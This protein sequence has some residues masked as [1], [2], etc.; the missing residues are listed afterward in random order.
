MHFKSFFFSTFFSGHWPDCP[1]GNPRFFPTKAAKSLHNSPSRCLYPSLIL[2][3]YKSFKKS[4]MAIPFNPSFTK[5]KKHGRY[6]TRSLQK[7]NKYNIIFGQ[8]KIT[9][10]YDKGNTWYLVFNYLRHR[11]YEKADNDMCKKRTFFLLIIHT[12]WHFPPTLSSCSVMPESLFTPFQSQ[13]TGIQRE[14][15]GTYFYSVIYLEI[16]K[17]TVV[18][19]GKHRSDPAYGGELRER[20]LKLEVIN[21]EDRTRKKFRQNSVQHFGKLASTNAWLLF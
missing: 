4:W 16:S 5:S 17:C 19:R 20:S 9:S 14:V 2:Q 6:F 10:N 13:V 12:Q 21:N 3:M 18:A 8:N 15:N 1:P 11:R 7:H